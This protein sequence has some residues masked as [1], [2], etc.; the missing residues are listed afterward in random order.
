MVH[1]DR[2]S[3]GVNHAYRGGLLLSWRFTP[4]VAVYSYRG[5]LL[6]SWWFTLTELMYLVHCYPG[7]DCGSLLPNCESSSLLPS[8]CIWFIATLVVCVCVCVCV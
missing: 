4:I 1:S 6:L 3:A 7:S 2:G 8:L 5:G